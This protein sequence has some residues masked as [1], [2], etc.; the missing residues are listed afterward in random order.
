VADATAY[1]AVG[2]AVRVL[3]AGMKVPFADTVGE[4]A[5]RQLVGGGGYRRAA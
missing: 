1:A 2:A 3:A 4:K 5:M